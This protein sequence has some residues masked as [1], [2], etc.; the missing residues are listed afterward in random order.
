MSLLRVFLLFA[1]SGFIFLSLILHLCSPS[2]FFL[3]VLF[4]SLP[5]LPFP[6]SP[7]LRGLH[8]LFFSRVHTTST[9][10]PGSS[11][12]L[13]LLLLFL[14][15]TCFLFGLFC[16]L[17]ASITIA[18]TITTTTTTQFLDVLQCA[19]CWSV[20]V[21]WFFT[22]FSLPCL[23]TSHCSLLCLM[24]LVVFISCKTARKGNISCICGMFTD[25]LLLVLFTVDS[26]LVS[27]IY[28]IS[29]LSSSYLFFFPFT[30]YLFHL[31]YYYR[32]SRLVWLHQ[33]MYFF[34]F[35]FS[36]LLM[37]S[38]FQCSLLINNLLSFLVSSLA[39]R[40]TLR[41][42]SLQ[43]FILLFVCLTR[44]ISSLHLAIQPFT[45]VYSLV[46]SVCDFTPHLCVNSILSS[47]S[48]IYP[49]SSQPFADLHLL[50]YSSI[51]P[52]IIPISVSLVLLLIHLPMLLSSCLSVCSS[53]RSSLSLYPT[54]PC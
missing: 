12:R 1:T 8:Q 3:A 35:F 51:F 6:F 46:Q 39:L 41:L 5:A 37:S 45:W 15:C 49:L 24:S 25:F 48:P 32:V 50:V 34:F 38:G 40:S 22:L 43:S 47:L 36:V 4:F 18:A 23:F 28:F 10:T 44:K 53:V 21:R 11:W 54:S 27:V 13:Q 16:W 52:P 2:I 20:M 31:V 17:P 7:F 14:L 19:S 9:L 33:F 42:T 26:R 30:C 29:L